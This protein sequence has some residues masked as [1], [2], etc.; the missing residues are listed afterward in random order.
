VDKD[1][2]QII[3]EENTNRDHEQKE[4]KLLSK[5]V[6]SV[7]T[8]IHADFFMAGHQKESINVQDTENSFTEFHQNIRGPLNK[9]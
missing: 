2:G 6:R 7:P 9:S 4:D 8:T 3:H 5:R 1:C